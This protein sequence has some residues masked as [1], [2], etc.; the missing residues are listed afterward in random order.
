MGERG[1]VS[2]LPPW[3]Q[4]YGAMPPLPP[5]ID[6]EASWGN[7]P[8]FPLSRH[9]TRLRSHASPVHGTHQ[10][11]NNLKQIQFNVLEC[12]IGRLSWTCLLIVTPGRLTQPKVRVGGKIKVTKNKGTASLISNCQNDYD[13]TQEHTSC[14]NPMTQINR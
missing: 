2:P 8:G 9:D 12:L 7:G 11:M 13:G 14:T 4:D 10:H 3:A 5:G 6:S 1:W